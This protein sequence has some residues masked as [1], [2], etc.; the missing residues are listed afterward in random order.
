MDAR[1]VLIQ[2]IVRSA[3]LIISLFQMSK[4]SANARKI[5]R[6]WVIVVCNARKLLGVLNVRTLSI[7]KNATSQPTFN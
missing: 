6:W 3:T 7:A 5:L 1:S 4:E 2:T